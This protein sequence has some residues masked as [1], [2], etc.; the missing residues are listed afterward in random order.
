VNVDCL[1]PGVRAGLGLGLYPPPLT[2]VTSSSVST[3]VS[4]GLAGLNAAATELARLGDRAAAAA[5]S[6]VSPAG[7]TPWSLSPFT[8]AGVD[9]A[10]DKLCRLDHAAAADSNKNLGDYVNKQ[11]CVDQPCV[12]EFSILCILFGHCACTM[13]LYLKLQ[14]IL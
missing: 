7:L 1:N 8:A 13:Y 11:R 9:K 2:A 4:G 14:N 3:S 5:A 10:T 6:V 12:N